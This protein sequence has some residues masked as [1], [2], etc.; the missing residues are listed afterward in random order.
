MW[1]KT[2][3]CHYF[4]KHPSYVHDI[5]NKVYFSILSIYDLINKYIYQPIKDLTFS[6]RYSKICTTWFKLQSN[7]S[8]FI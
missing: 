5:K 1:V 3:K 4:F 6:D 8:Y 7:L 2:A